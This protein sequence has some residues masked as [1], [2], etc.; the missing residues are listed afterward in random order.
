MTGTVLLQRSQAPHWLYFQNPLEIISTSDPTQIR[1]MLDEIEEKVN[2]HNLYAAG[3]IAY[4]AASAF[5]PAMQVHP[6]ASL[7]LLWFGLYYFPV[8]HHIPIAAKNTHTISDWQPTIDQTQYRQA[9]EHIKTC[10][11]RGETYQVNYTIRLRANFKGNPLSLFNSLIASQ[12]SDY[13]AYIDT[14]STIIC[15]ASPELFFQRNG[16]TLVSKPMKGTAAR[17]KTLVED[18]QHH[19]WLHNSPKNRAENVMIVDMIRND[20]G[21]VAQTGSV[22]VPQLFT[23]ERYPTVLQMT[24]TVTAQTQATTTEILAALF[25]CAS[26]TGAP[27]VRTMEII[28]QLEPEPRGIYT[29]CIGYIAPNQ[30][31]QFNVAIRTVSIDERSGL[32]EYGVGG[33][34]VWDSMSEQEYEECRLKARILT[35][36]QPQFELLETLLWEPASGYFLRKKHLGRL[37][38]SAHYFSISFDHNQLINQLQ[39]LAATFD[40]PHRV[41][42]LVGSNGQIT[43]QAVPFDPTPP[44]KSWRVALASEP[45]DSNNIFLY[46][47]TTHR[48]IYSDAKAARPGFDDVILWNERGQITEA[49]IANVVIQRGDKLFTPPI[50]CGLLA[51]TYRA[52]LLAQQKIREQIITIDDLKRS[53]R[54]YLINSV[55]KWIEAVFVS[56]Q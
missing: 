10:I 24:S 14:G 18:E 46:H 19:A 4:E 50:E 20:M 34:V 51:G 40:R 1:P 8:E 22:K 38:D 32:A 41:R 11:G 26:I 27:K 43:T 52:S 35:E 45:V 33:G 16:T 5:D 31:A 3:F 28:K 44:S 23:V 25:P 47:K 12:R 15:S 39:S 29:G 56:E 6:S 2:R 17:G 7:P 49:T 21:R 53:D 13:A 54:L 48:Q 55:R 42:L 36:A 37:N 30:Q 9:I